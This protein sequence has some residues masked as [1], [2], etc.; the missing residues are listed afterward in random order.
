MP[1]QRQRVIFSQFH[2]GCG[3]LQRRG[4]PRAVQRLAEGLPQRRVVCLAGCT[5]GSSAQRP[6]EWSAAVV[7]FL[8]DIEAGR[9]ISGEVTV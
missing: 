5:H 6:D 8:D 4:L 3:P 7:R 2:T 1:H 9:E